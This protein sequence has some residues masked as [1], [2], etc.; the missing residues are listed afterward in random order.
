[1]RIREFQFEQNVQKSVHIPDDL[2]IHPVKK[3]S[4]QHCT[5]AEYMSQKRKRSVFFKSYISH[6]RI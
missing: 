6:E 5:Y 2:K 1:M 4:Q 3:L